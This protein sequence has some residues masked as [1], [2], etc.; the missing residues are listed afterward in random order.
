MFKAEE[1]AD[2]RELEVIRNTLTDLSNRKKYIFISDFGKKIKINRL[3]AEKSYTVEIQTLLVK[4]SLHE[5]MR[6][7]D[8][9][10][11]STDEYI[12]A[13]LYALP[14]RTPPEGFS[15]GKETEQIVPGSE[16]IVKC[17]DCHG[18]SESVNNS[19][20]HSCQSCKGSGEM[21][22]Y[23]YYRTEYFPK[24]FNAGLAP[25]KIPQKKTAE[26]AGSYIFD[27]I[28]YDRI[29]NADTAWMK[30]AEFECLNSAVKK[31]LDEIKRYLKEEDIEIFRI[32]LR[33]HDNR[34]RKV[35]YTFRNKKQFLRIMGDN[36]LYAKKLVDWRKA[37]PIGLAG[38]VI[39]ITGLFYAAGAGYFKPKLNQ[40]AVGIENRANKKNTAQPGSEVIDR[41]ITE[42]SKIVTNTGREMKTVKENKEEL[43]IEKT[44]KK[45]KVLFNKGV[46]QFKE[47]EIENAYNNLKAALDLNK[48][49]K[50]HS[51]IAPSTA[52]MYFYLGEVFMSFENYEEAIAAY[53]VAL[54]YDSN[55]DSVK[56][57]LERAKSLK[58]IYEKK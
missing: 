42:K 49:I 11:I 18:E 34:L 7:H 33:A 55:H 47:G 39:L 38:S 1:I 5:G 2:K 19:S 29:K 56:K 10:R 57:S 25:L 26:G 52:D 15:S 17:D 36:L 4:R 44:I 24:I 43:L 28:I 58:S 53:E 50:N 13:S 22:R 31:M 14:Y 3:T 54:I 16:N 48:E 45:R 8:G 32:R 35:E 20:K 23:S 30:L 6:A 46:S 12:P 9:G 41:K 27:G 51:E 40:E 37:F 21:V